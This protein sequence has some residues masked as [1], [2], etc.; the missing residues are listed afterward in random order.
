MT[1]TRPAY[2][3]VRVS[4]TSQ[5]DGHGFTRQG[6]AITAYAEAHGLDVRAVYL[7]PAI[8]GT[9][10]LADRPGLKALLQAVESDGVRVLVIEALDRLA[11]DLMVQELILAKLRIVGVELASTREGEDVAGDDPTRK[12]L[13]QFMGAIAEWDKENTVRRLRAAR[14]AKRA[15]T[16]KGEGRKGY[17]DSASAEERQAADLI[18]EHRRAGRTYRH[19]AQMLNDRQVPTRNGGKWY[20]STVRGVFAAGKKLK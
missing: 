10:D 17:A 6:E 2:G 11:R 14:V 8:S 19:I 1:E 16:G 12:L 4:G 9:S 20:P 3:Y 18:S 15:K 7:D 13:R 5:L